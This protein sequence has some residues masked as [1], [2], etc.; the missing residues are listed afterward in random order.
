M[1]FFKHSVGSLEEGSAQSKTFNPCRIN[2]HTHTH[3]NERESR[4]QMGSEPTISVYERR[5]TVLALNRAASVTGYQTLNFFRLGNN[6]NTRQVYAVRTQRALATKL[7][8][9]RAKNNYH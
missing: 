5:K 9:H 8:A 1:N 2:Q 7:Q 3:T 4:P 6:P